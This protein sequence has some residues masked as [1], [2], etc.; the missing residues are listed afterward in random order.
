VV[1]DEA[2]RFTLGP[3]DAGTYGL[4]VERLGYQTTSSALA[5]KEGETIGV[6]LR[7]AVEAIPLDPIVV[8]VSPRPTW[9]YTEPPS[10]WEFWERREQLGKIGL[11]S[12][13]TEKDLKPFLGQKISYT[14]ANLHPF[15][16]AFPH[17]YRPS[18][19][20]IRGRSGCKPLIYVDGHLVSPRQPMEGFDP[21]PSRVRG[22][23]SQTL[24]PDSIGRGEESMDDF[25]SA[26]EIAAI[27]VYRGASDLPGEFHSGSYS[28]NCGAVVIWSRRGIRR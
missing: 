23:R 10:L 26:S 27:E 1:S 8:T 11:G 6:E 21:P 5:M 22:I 24:I 15:L 25:I 7:L 2:G 16:D 19:V 12:F 18:T 20:L 17:S 4:V 3:I 28:S 14:V 13:I 9:E